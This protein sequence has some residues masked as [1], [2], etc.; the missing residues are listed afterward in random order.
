MICSFETAPSFEAV[1]QGKPVSGAQERVDAIFAELRHRICTAR[2]P[3]GALVHEAAL[4]EEFEV[5][6]SALRRAIG[7]LE[8]ARLL[9]IIHGVGI[10]V[11]EVDS[12]ELLDIFRTRMMLA[13]N[14]GPFFQSPLPR[15]AVDFLEDCITRWRSLKRNDQA[16][17]GDVNM[18]YFSGLLNLISSP[19]LRDLQ[20]DLFYQS[21][22]MWLHLLPTLDWHDTIETICGE[23]QSQ[24]YS[25]ATNDPEGLAFA[26]RTT[27]RQAMQRLDAEVY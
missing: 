12:E 27:I 14:S 9:E 13:A 23:L 8:Q 24:Q 26:M 5:G 25:I 7:K 1:P 21:S 3:P 11:T 22:R 17:F 4:A 19:S 15:E 18:Y 20:A 10:R 2:I 6:R 16:S